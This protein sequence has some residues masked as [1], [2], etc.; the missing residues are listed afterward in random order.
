MR[1]HLGDRYRVHTISF[2][3]SSPMHIDATFNII[4][5]GLVITNPD[6]PCNQL[7]L[8]HKAGWKIVTAPQ[9]AIY[10]DHPLWMASRWLSMNV[11]MLDEKRVVVEKE[12]VP[13]QKMFEKLGI[14]CIK[15]HD[16]FFFLFIIILSLF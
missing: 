6:R 4:G 9:P 1:R 12:E 14:E 5:P 16:I 11:L 3:D 2:K 7:D 15:V 13:I 8:F 10:N